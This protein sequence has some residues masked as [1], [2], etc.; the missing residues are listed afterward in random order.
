MA[1]P[2]IYFSAVSMASCLTFS[3]AWKIKSSVKCAGDH[4]ATQGIPFCFRFEYFQEQPVS[5]KPPSAFVP[6]KRIHPFSAPNVD[7]IAPAAT[8]YRRG[9]YSPD[10]AA[11]HRRKARW[12]LSEYSPD[13]SHHSNRANHINDDRQ[14]S[15]I[16]CRFRYC[17][18][19]LMNY[20]PRGSW[21]FPNRRNAN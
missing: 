4:D 6:C 17:F 1:V 18:F 2:Y 5:R 9:H 16:Q 15:S 7:T 8:Q 14:Q 3:Q 21:H 10:I 12:N 13:H 11:P 20:F 19:W